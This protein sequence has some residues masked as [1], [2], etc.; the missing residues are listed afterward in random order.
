MT[1]S[2]KAL[3]KNRTSIR[4]GAIRWLIVSGILLVSGIVI[5]TGAMVGVFRERALHSAERE[6]DNTVLLLARHFDQQLEDFV[7]IQREVAAE[8]HL[9][10]L[11]SPEAFRARM[12]T[13]DFHEALRAKVSGHFD[14]AGINIF[15]ADGRLINSSESWPVPNINVADRSYFKAFKAGT[16]PTSV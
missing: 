6:L 3:F 10:R 14:V 13:A 15:D 2:G 11:T 4:G 12:S 8:S 1:R 16:A 5:G 7:T 9:A